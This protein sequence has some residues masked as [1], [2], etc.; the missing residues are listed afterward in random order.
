MYASPPGS[1]RPASGTTTSNQ[2]RK[3]GCRI[4]RGRVISSTASL[5][6]G[7]R[8][9]RELPQPALE[10]GEVA[11]AEADGGGVELAVRERQR[12]RVALHP[13][14][15]AGL[16][17]RP[18]EHP[19]GEVE[20]DDSSASPLGLD[21]EVAGPAAGVEHAISGPDDLADG[22]PPPAP[23][24]P[25]GHDAV[26]DV[27]DR[28]RCGRTCP[29]T[30]SGASVP[31]SYVTRLAPARDERIVDPDLVEAA[32]D[33]EVDE[34][35]DRLGAVVEAGRGEED[36]RA[37]LVQR[38]EPAEV[39]RGERR[40]ARHEHE[41]AALLQRHRRGA[42]DEVL[43]RSGRERPDRGHRARADHV[44]VDAGGA[45]RIRAAEVVLAVHGDLRRGASDEPLEHLLAG[46]RRVAVEL[47]REHLDPRAGRTEP[48]L[49]VRRLRAR[50]AAVPRR[51]R[52][53]RRSRRGRRARRQATA[54]DRLTG[55]ATTRGA[56]RA[57][58]PLYL[59]PLEAARNA[60]SAARFSCPR[61]E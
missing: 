61:Y 11:H 38:R 15:R 33:D 60:P 52:R 43:H 50:A 44:G 17:P 32:R 41:L 49:A 42:V 24:E 14:D 35:V 36:D 8:T 5:P 20:P 30:V 9:R 10:V 47:G 37:G 4:P 34:V 55:V 39:D 40:L 56:D 48:D 58:S 46:E 19:L 54:E 31:D 51:E 28:A 2:S 23:V 12:E 57:R 22:E 3:N 27:V 21:R 25:D 45:A 7:R 59:G 6:P 13:L 29:R 1:T 18:L 53:T 16:A 26:H